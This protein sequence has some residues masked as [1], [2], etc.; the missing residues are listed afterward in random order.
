MKL[1]TKSPVLNWHSLGFTIAVAIA[2]TFLTLAFITGENILFLIVILGIIFAVLMGTIKEDIY[3]RPPQP[4]ET[5]RIHYVDLIEKTKDLEGKTETWMI[6]TYLSEGT[7][8]ID[9][10]PYDR[11]IRVGDFFVGKGGELKKIDY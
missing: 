5:I 4:G 2:V 1:A 7:L 9:E 11:D 8:F 6:Y 10:V 3:K